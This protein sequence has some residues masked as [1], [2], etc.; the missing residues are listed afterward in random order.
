MSNLYTGVINSET[1][2]TVSSLT[3]VTFTEG[4]TYVIQIQNQAQLREGTTGEGFLINSTQP[5]KYTAGSDDLYIQTPGGVIPCIINI[6][7]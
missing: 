7:E 6:A 5:F 4:N 1:F 3:G 2:A